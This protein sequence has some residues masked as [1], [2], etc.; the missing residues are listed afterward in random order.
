MSS[1]PSEVVLR[2]QAL[3]NEHGGW[4][5]IAEPIVLGLLLAPSPAAA[6]I[7]V[8]AVAAFL[9]RHP[10][11]LAA[12]D[13]L[14]GR[15]YPRTSAC[16]WLACGYGATAL[17]SMTVAVTLSGPR[18]LIPFAIAAPFAL[19]QFAADAKNRGRALAAELAGAVAMGSIAVAMG[20]PAAVWA[21]LAARSVPA[22]LY[23]RAALR[24]EHVAIAVAAHVAAVIIAYVLWPPATL[25][26]LLLLARCI[27]GVAR[28]PRPAKVVGV[29]EL[30]Y[31][32]AFVITC[33]L[34]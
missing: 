9:M 23:V 21:V 7:A 15:R 24:R 28:K 27:E 10:L 33:R 3:P 20:A 29:M 34:S 5:F 25:A 31:G 19:A 13:W 4:G 26:M 1:R 30:I 6:F 14:R 8:A 32:A 11:K 22:I 18:L 16:E 12:S 2:P 17:A